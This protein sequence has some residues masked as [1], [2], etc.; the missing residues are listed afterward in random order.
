MCWLLEAEAGLWRDW[1]VTIALRCLCEMADHDK[2]TPR[3]A[4]PRSCK[5]LRQF[6]TCQ[7]LRRSVCLVL[8]DGPGAVRQPSRTQNNAG[9]TAHR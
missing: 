9:R 4:L 3:D 6:C 2:A 5:A 1:W 7:R 8:Q